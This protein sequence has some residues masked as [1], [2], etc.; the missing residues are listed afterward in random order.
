MN[1]FLK[2]QLTIHSSLSSKTKREAPENKSFVF[3]DVITTRCAA[4]AAL[5]CEYAHLAKNI[6]AAASRFTTCVKKLT[7]MN[8]YIYMYIY[9]IG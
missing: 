9:S 5:I 7:H 6:M 4:R 1:P 8:H 2:S 3:G